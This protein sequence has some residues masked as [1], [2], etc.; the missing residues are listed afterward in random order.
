MKKALIII[1]TGI[2]LGLTTISYAD[3]F[4]EAH[5]NGMLAVAQKGNAKAQN[6]VAFMYLKGIGVNQDYQE[7]IKWFKI[8]ANNGNA[9]AQF[10]LGLQYDKANNLTEAAKWYKK[11]AE[12][13]FADAQYNIGAMYLDGA[14]VER[15]YYEAARWIKNAAE[16]G[17]ADAQLILGKM[18][19]DGRGVKLN[20]EQAVKWVIMSAKQGH[21]EAQQIL[22][23]NGIP[24]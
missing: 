19:S 8:S 17:H 1:A 21:V 3:I 23:R 6:E 16:Q 22:D 9:E 13:G 10:N 2:F 18:Y 24:Y 5:F 4:E 15:N 11:A 20:K 12:Q 14:G 7:A